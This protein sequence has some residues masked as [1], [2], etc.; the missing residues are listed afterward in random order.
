MAMLDFDGTLSLIRA[1]WLSVMASMMVEALLALQTG[2]TEAALRAGTVAM[3]HRTTGEPTPVQMEAF[4]A[5]IAA[6]G[7]T[8]PSNDACMDRY[9]DRLGAVIGERREAVA[10]GREPTER[11]LVPGARG[12]LD[13]LRQRGI[14][15]ILASGTDHDQVVLEAELLGITPY[16]NLG[17]CGAVPPP[18]VFSKDLLVERLI[19]EGLYRGEEMLA[20]G[21]GPVEIAAVAQAGGVAVG[22]ASDEQSPGR[23]ETGKRE[24][25][26]AAGAH[27]IVPDFAEHQALLHTLFDE[28][29]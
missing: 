27:I 14:S 24:R 10:S 11:Y 25:L 12:L 8:P 13:G 9:R 3:I 18:A 19:R 26:I 4:R 2:E 7:G 28:G 23:L 29:V 1:G 6:R 15:M 5:A 22:I 17:I 20:F 21:D 16:F